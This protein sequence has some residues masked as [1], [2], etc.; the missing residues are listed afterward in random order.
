MK[1]HCFSVIQALSNNGS[2]CYKTLTWDELSHPTFIHLPYST[3]TNIHI[4]KSYLVRCHIHVIYLCLNHNKTNLFPCYFL[5]KLVRIFHPIKNDISWHHHEH[6]YS[7]F[8]GMFTFQFN[9]VARLFSLSLARLYCQT[10]KIRWYGFGITQSKAN[11][12]KCH[13]VQ[14]YI[15]YIYLWE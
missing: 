1:I 4:I 10:M 11:I 9:G 12:S 5:V 15:R 14:C 8:C 2:E 7:T 13:L 3:I 6:N